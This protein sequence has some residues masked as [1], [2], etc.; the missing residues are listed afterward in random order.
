MTI[1]EAIQNRHSVRR[2]T[3]KNVNNEILSALEAEVSDCN[4][5]SGLNIRLVANDPETF[6]V[7][8]RHAPAE[9]HLY[10][11]HAREKGRRA[12]G[13]SEGGIYR[14]G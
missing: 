9:S 14:G 7:P 8:L 13:R 5:E 6:I 1:I 4:A 2:F 10:R 11:H 12:G 3:E